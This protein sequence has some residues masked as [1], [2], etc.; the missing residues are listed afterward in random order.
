MQGNASFKTIKTRRPWYRN[1]G[2]L[3]ATAVILLLAA[4]VGYLMKGDEATIL[5]RVKAA[6]AISP[7]CAYALG[8]RGIRS[9]ATRD[10]FEQ[11]LASGLTDKPA[12]ESVRCAC[13]WSLGRMRQKHSVMYLLDA[14]EKEK[15]ISVRCAAARALGTS[16]EPEGRDALIAAVGD[17]EGDVRAAAAEGCGTL[18]DQGA[19]DALIDRLDDSLPDVRRN[20]HDSLVKITGRSFEGVDEKAQ[21]R[22]WREKSR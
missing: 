1:P 6:D 7:V 14:L 3:V 19:V 13:A 11:L 4:V 15:S 2:A 18:G 17:G 16:G 8:F 10:A 21:W 9:D 5:A 20:C 12:P 22:R